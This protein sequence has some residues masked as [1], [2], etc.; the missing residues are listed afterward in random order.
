MEELGQLVVESD[1]IEAG[2][3]YE[4]LSEEL[5]RPALDVALCTAEPTIQLPRGE[6]A[7]LSFIYLRRRCRRRSARA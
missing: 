4:A 7:S 2:E 1:N 5:Q 6:L 3:L